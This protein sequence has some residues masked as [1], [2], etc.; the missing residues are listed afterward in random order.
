[1][2]K[3]S[4]SFPRCDL[5]WS[6]NSGKYCNENQT[7]EPDAYTSERYLGDIVRY[8]KC[9]TLDANGQSTGNPRY[10]NLKQVFL[11]SRTYGGYA[12]NH[13]SSGEGSYAGCLSPEP[14]AYEERF[15]VQRLIVAQINQDA[16]MQFTDPYLGTVA[17]KS[18]GTGNAPW[19]DWGPYLWTSGELG[20]SDGLAWCN[21]RGTLLC[22]PLDRD[23]RDGDDSPDPDDAF[24]GDYTHPRDR[25]QEKVADQLLYFITN[26]G[27][28]LGSQSYIVNWVNPWRLK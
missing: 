14:Y 19:F 1:M 16:G 15:A 9:C 3:S 27:S 22:D 7:T 13:G 25:G 23:V 11:T 21:G 4:T 2:F 6:V 28:L 10:P 8:L 18:D 20:R 24:W 17:Y 5:N 26:Q 12:K